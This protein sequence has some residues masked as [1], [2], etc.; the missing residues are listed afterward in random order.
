MLNISAADVVVDPYPHIV[1]D[2]ML[3]PAIFARL[4]ADYPDADLFAENAADT[5][6]KGSRAGKE[7]GFDIY[8]GDTSYDRLIARSAAWSEFDAWINSRA[9]VDRYQELFGPYARDIGISVDIARSSYD[10]GYVEPRDVLT[11]TETMGEKIAGLTHRLTRP[12]RM[13]Q[14]TDLFSR[15][16]I[17]RSL[18]G[19]AKPPHCDRPN[20]LCSLII[21]FTDADEVGLEG[22]D[23]L[24]FKAKKP[25]PIERAPRHPHPHEVE[26]VAQLRPKA[27][28]GVFFPCCNNSYHGVT[29]V[30]SKG[31]PRD[32]LYINISG[33][34]ASLW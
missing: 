25:G 18:G 15:L 6:S 5:G 16:D 34:S 7:T 28:R 1:S 31:V 17:T 32:F 23:L 2:S 10:R 12:M 22:G 9:F 33:R 4:R 8:R 26:I 30:T 27:N 21:Y 14:P 19:Y 11:A 24:V 20:R 3:D 13:G 29:A